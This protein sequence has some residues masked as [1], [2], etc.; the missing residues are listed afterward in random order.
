MSAL[1]IHSTAEDIPYL[2]QMRKADLLPGAYYNSLPLQKYTHWN[3]GSFWMTK[4]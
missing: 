3:P 1:N 2:L 4:P